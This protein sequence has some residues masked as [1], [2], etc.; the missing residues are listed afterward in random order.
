MV[1]GKA[2]VSMRITYIEHSGFAVEWENCIW[3]FDYYRGEIPSWDKKK[4][5]VVFS[6]HVHQDHF[7]PDIFDMFSEFEDV[8]YILSSDIRKKVKKLNLEEDL[9]HR[10][11]YMKPGEELFLTVGD[12]EELE[13]WTLDST[14]CGVSFMVRY[15]G[16]NIFHAGD[17][18]CWVW[19]EDSKA[20]KNDMISRYQREINKL[21]HIPVSYAFLPLDHRLGDN[22]D[23]GIRYFM[24]HV[25][26]SHVF[27]M[28][29]W[30]RYSTVIKF[31]DSLE[32]EKEKEKVVSVSY[33]GQQWEFE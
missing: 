21:I 23:L 12:D 26:V 24:E 2:G 27:P 30:G 7:V 16:K 10:I 8:H 29:L 14:D 31:R 28:H 15:E 25:E 19:D 11:D 5:L 3:V 22:Y 33:T 17:L 20:E 9:N 18:N 1:Y 4:P 32:D 13:I 6:S